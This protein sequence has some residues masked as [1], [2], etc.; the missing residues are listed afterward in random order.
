[1]YILTNL[2]YHGIVGK[3]FTDTSCNIIW[4]CLPRLA[5]NDLSIRQRHFDGCGLLS[6]ESKAAVVMPLR[7]TVY[8]SDQV[9]YTAG[10]RTCTY[11]RPQT[12]M[13]G[14]WVQISA[15]IP[16][17]I[18]CSHLS[19]ATQSSYSFFKRSNISS[20]GAKNSGGGFIYE[21]NV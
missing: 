18:T 15:C 21:G 14:V 20:R 3:T 8:L 9:E 1:M 5:L 2:C 4:S 11:L 12:S 6:C 17:I 19:P 13:V 16:A 7:E 10:V